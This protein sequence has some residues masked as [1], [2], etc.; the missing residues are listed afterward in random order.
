MKRTK[1]AT[2]AAK[3]HNGHKLQRTH[4]SSKYRHHNT[5]PSIVELLHRFGFLALD[6]CSN[7]WSMLRAAIA[8]CGKRV[9]DDGLRAD[10]IALLALAV[11]ANSRTVRALIAFAFVNPP[12][13]RETLVW[14][15]KVVREARRGAEVITLTAARHDTAWW[16]LLFGQAAAVAYVRGRVR[17]YKRGK[18][19]DASFFPSA[20]LYFGAHPDRFCETFGTIADC[21]RIERG[22][23]AV[24]RALPNEAPPSPTLGQ[25]NGANYIGGA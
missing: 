18:E 21:F 8:L 3:L 20:I 23:I 11:K 4:G 6:P 12:Y 25:G 2:R 10:W 22:R 15:A 7:R 14:A 17:H 16:R 19:Q 13:G 24:L 5:P 9:S 1:R